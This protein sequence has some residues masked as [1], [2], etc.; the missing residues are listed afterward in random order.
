MVVE[1]VWLR[2]SVAVV[3]CVVVRSTIVGT[4][5]VKDSVTVV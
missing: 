5:V 1:N 3:G 4:R 2:V